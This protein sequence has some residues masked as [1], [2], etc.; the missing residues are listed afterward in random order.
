[1]RHRFTQ[2]QTGPQC[3]FILGSP[4]GAC[5]LSEAHA[6]HLM[7]PEQEDHLRNIWRSFVW[8]VESKYRLGAVEHGGMLWDK[9]PLQLV[10]EAMAETVDQ[11][12]FLHTLRSKLLSGAT[13]RQEGHSG[14][15]E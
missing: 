6:I 12:T 3:D 4:P 9:T 2:S 1:V 10:E 7:A 5:G 15:H 13:P 14:N 11:Y 8:E